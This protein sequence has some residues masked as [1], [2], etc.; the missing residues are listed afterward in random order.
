M[1]I[2]IKFAFTVYEY[3][4]VYEYLS[5]YPINLIYIYIYIYRNFVF[6]VYCNIVATYTP[7]KHTG[8]TVFTF[9]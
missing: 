3:I 6:F 5:Y 9:T 7:H 2:N 4:I 8:H 1:Q